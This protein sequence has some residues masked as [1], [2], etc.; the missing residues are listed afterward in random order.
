MKKIISL[1]IT[2][3][4]MFSCVTSFA[5]TLNE[6]VIASLLNQL[7]IMKGDEDGNLRLYDHISRAEFS[8]VAIATSAYRN[9]VA[10]NITISP[11]KDVSY[12]HW[13][14]P[15]IK[16]A[17]TN[18]YISGYPDGTFLPENNLLYEEALTIMLKILG[19]TDDD[20]GSSWP[21]GQIAL[22]VNLELIKN[23]DASA[24]MPITRREVMQLVY[25]A[26]DTKPKGGSSP[27]IANIN[28]SIT[29]DVML[30]A[31]SNEDSSISANMVLIATSASAAQNSGGAGSGSSGGSGTYYKLN[32]DFDYSL[33]GKKGT[34][35]TKNSDEIVSFIPNEQQVNTYNIYQILGDSIIVLENNELKTLD[36]DKNLI[37]YN[38]TSK[39]NL[40][41]LMLTLNLGDTLTIYKTSG[42]VLD[43]GF[44][45]TNVL[46]NPITVKNSGWLSEIGLE[47]PTV[48]RDGVKTDAPEIQTND[49]LYY[50][51]NINMVWA[52]SKKVTGI[53]ED[54][55]PNKDNLISIKLSGNSFLVEGI[56]AFNKLSSNG[57]INYGDTITVLLGKSGNIVDVLEATEGGS[58]TVIGYLLETGRKEYNTTNFSTYTANYVKLL[59]S[60]GQVKE[61]TTDK[62]YSLQKNK[63]VTFTFASKAI[64][65]ITSTNR[66]SGTIED[67]KIN[68]LTLA[69]NLKIVDVYAAGNSQYELKNKTGLYCTVF[70]KR[71]EGLSLKITDVLY[72][73][74][75]NRNEISK[76]YLNNVTG[77]IFKYGIVTSAATNK[78]S[79]NQNYGYDINGT[80][81]NVSLSTIFLV[82]TGQPAKFEL[83]NDKVDAIRPLVK[84]NTTIT[85][86]NTDTLE[87]ANSK[88]T[89]SENVI[90][91]EKDEYTYKYLKMTKSDI[92]NSSD[93][94]FQAYYDKEEAL[95]G[96]IRVI[97]AE[98][99][100][101]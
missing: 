97:I 99:K 12:T 45:E 85:K 37:V 40:N 16:L 21:Y 24:G 6:E 9:G 2:A 4:I 18:K 59:E 70:Q 86:V 48:V 95:G 58:S 74:Q 11:F 84:V 55:T 17:V 25:N 64:K 28:Y 89:L 23:I 38:K 77:D 53:Y 49:I 91:Y 30:I 10:K 93:Y 76:L 62:D 20:F 5:V 56:E 19:Y 36:I 79:S 75:N 8:K 88:Y 94:K 87:T 67:G 65:A 44:V 31:T 34:L 51:K 57:S 39:T 96:R 26:L 72:Y 13:A 47:N 98:K 90:I 43:Y 83:I 54:A 100:S 80:L 1:L 27:Y 69:D 35:I 32:L 71:I 68:G 78:E 50:S 7:D 46:S 81:G 15:Y 61:Y 82:A 14:A 42:G 33:V 22:A 92:V 29:D 3:S 66:L 41:S 63:M 52:Y 73:E 60:D 101:K